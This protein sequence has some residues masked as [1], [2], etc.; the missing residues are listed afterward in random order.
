MSDDK[1][2]EHEYNAENIEALS[3]REHIR[4]RPGMYIGGTDNRA[5]YY[6]F[7]QLVN[8][9]LDEVFAEYCDNIRVVF[10]SSTC[11]SVIDNGLGIPVDIDESEKSKF[12]LVMSGVGTKCH[13]F[14]E[15]TYKVSGGWYGIGIVTNNALSSECIAESKRD[16]YLWR[17]TYSEGLVTSPVEQVRPLAEDESTGTSI[18]FTPDFTIMDEG[19]TF[20]YDIILERCQ[21]LAYLLPQLTLEI[22]RDGEILS[23]NQPQGLAGW[24]ADLNQYDEL[25]HPVLSNSLEIE[26]SNKYIGQST[27]KVELALQFRKNDDGFV[28]G[29]INTILARD[30]GTHIE[31]LRESLIEA[32][33]GDNVHQSDNPLQGLTAILHIYHPDPQ[34]ESQTKVKILNPEIKEAVAQCVQ[35]LLAENPDVLVRLQRHFAG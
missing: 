17:Q 5:F 19:L 3:P 25:V 26:Y 22:E 11:L 13:K 12:E 35:A 6:L 18:T 29:F 31:G 24:V 8:E 30:G 34:F 2:Q 27:L 28:M 7:W 4:K 1:P 15:L 16:G 10:H 33:Y 14:E 20:D 23:L 21:E 32:I 9:A